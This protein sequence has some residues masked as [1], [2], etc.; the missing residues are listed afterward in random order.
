M[1]LRATTLWAE[2]PSPRRQ[3]TGASLVHTA[4]LIKGLREVVLDDMDIISIDGTQHD[5]CIRITL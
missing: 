4:A 2:I 3:R 1:T 5:P